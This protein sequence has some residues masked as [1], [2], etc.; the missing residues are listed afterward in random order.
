M[1]EATHSGIAA[2][3]RFARGLRDDLAGVNA[4]LTLEWSRGVTE[5]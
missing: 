1:A 4:G 3:A 2:L 5:G